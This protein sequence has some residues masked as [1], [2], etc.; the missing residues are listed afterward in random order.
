MTTLDS[1][2]A[3]A[4]AMATDSEVVTR[5]LLRTVRLPGGGGAMGLITLDNGQ[6][7]TRPNTIGPR[8][9]LELNTAIDAALAD[10]EVTSVGITGK[11][12][13]LAAGADLRAIAPTGPHGVRTIAELGH[14]VFR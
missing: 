7:H 6:D 10:D 9:L 11:P 1:L 5:A 12:F 13:I 4:E 8:S 14:A 2:L 3:R